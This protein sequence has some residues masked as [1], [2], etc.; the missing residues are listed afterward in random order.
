MASGRQDDGRLGVGN[1]AGEKPRMRSAIVRVPS[2]LRGGHERTRPAWSGEVSLAIRGTVV[3]GSPM[4]PGTTSRTDDCTEARRAATR[5]SYSPLRAAA[6][7]AHRRVLKARYLDRRRVDDAGARSSRETM[8]R[9]RRH[10]ETWPLR[11]AIALIA[12]R[13]RGGLTPPFPGCLNSHQRPGIG[14][15][16]QRGVAWRRG[17]MRRFEMVVITGRDPRP[18]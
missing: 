11:F 7:S 16:L 2:K 18:S 10:C 15:P 3:P 14:R 5:S 9:D 17:S 1:D 4:Q 8:F 13:N 12:Y 6:P